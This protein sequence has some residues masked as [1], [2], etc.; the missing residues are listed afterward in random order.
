MDASRETLI[1]V[2]GEDMVVNHS[3]EIWNLLIEHPDEYHQKILDH[4]A[5]EKIENREIC[6]KC[7]GQCCLKVPC[8]FA[9][10]D[11]E[12]LSYKAMKKL[13]KEK[14]YISVIKFSSMLRR[15]CLDDYTNDSCFYI[16]RIRTSDTGIAACAAEVEDDDLCMLLGKNGCELSYEDRPK[17][18]RMLVPKE[19]MPC[20][21]LYAMEDCV[22][23]WN[24]HQELL[25][26]LYMYFERMQK[27]KVIFK[28][29]H[30]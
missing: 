22:K 3:E 12:N 13:M 25:K 15:M 9:P 2:F 27:L 16:L 14:G 11:F 29:V 4:Y 24:K 20:Q 26:K 7:G 21:Q 28:R 5:G 10:D 23:D 18:A 19:K 17:G 8:H 30:L 6:K 1:E